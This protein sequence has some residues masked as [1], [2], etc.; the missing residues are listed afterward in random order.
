MHDMHHRLQHLHGAI[1]LTAYIP[2]RP[3]WHKR[4]NRTSAQL[5][6]GGRPKDVSMRCC[7]M[8]G[9]AWVMAEDASAS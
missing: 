1:I 6:I 4:R 3:C 8:A 7:R 2:P 5:S 9:K